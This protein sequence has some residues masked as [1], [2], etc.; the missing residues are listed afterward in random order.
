[1]R[2]PTRWS[3]SFECFGSDSTFHTV[4]GYGVPLAH[5]SLVRN[6]FTHGSVSP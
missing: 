5:R 1:M 3:T 6:E 2:D 4:N